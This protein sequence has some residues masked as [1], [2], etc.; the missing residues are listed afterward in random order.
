MV[1]KYVPIWQCTLC[2]YEGELNTFEVYIESGTKLKCSICPKCKSDMIRHSHNIKITPKVDYGTI[3]LLSTPTSR[4]SFWDFFKQ[5]D[6][7]K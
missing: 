5:Y 4:N 7:K 2:L 3:T 6:N 1:N